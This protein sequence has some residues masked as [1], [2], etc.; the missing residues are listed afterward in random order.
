MASWFNR[1]LRPTRYADFDDHDRPS[2]SSGRPGTSTTGQPTGPG[3]AATSSS[4][5]SNSLAATATAAPVNGFEYSA[6]LP[7]ERIKGIKTLFTFQS[8]EVRALL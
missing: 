1:W 6:L 4:V 8:W 5:A 2:S 7:R 3:G